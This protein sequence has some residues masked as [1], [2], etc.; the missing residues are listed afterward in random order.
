M[1]GDQRGADGRDA[2]VA[3]AL[4]VLHLGIGDFVGGPRNGRRG[5]RE[6]G[7]LDVGND[8]RGQVVAD[9]RGERKNEG[10]S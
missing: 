9:G 4:A 5:R 8:G 7:R 10:L 1:G 3:R 2:A 6:V